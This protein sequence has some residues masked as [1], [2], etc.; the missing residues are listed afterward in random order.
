MLDK[1]FY[2]INCKKIVSTVA[3]GTHN[4]N[5]CPYCLHSKH[6][7]I[8]IGDRS[9]K[10]LSDMYPIG[11]YLRKNQEEVLIHKCLKCGF[12]RYNRIAGDDNF[13]LVSKLKIIPIEEINN[14]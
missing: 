5:H 14:L 13:K 1:K 9:S 4:R 10:C 2:C 3:F 12:I 8:E 11:K 6:V 7:D